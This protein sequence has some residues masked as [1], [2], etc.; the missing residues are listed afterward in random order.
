MQNTQMGVKVL[1]FNIRN[2][3]VEIRLIICFI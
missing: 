2:A 3:S 1:S